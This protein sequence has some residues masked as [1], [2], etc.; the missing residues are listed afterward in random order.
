MP[1]HVIV[2][3]G[4]VGS[5]TA[6]RLAEAGHDIR[7]VTRSGHGPDHPGVERIAADA[8]DAARLTELAR[9]AHALYNCANPPYH[10]WATEWPPL[11][12]SFLAAAEATEARLITMSNLYGHARGTMPMRATDP[13]APPTRKGAIRTAMWHDALRA[14]GEGRIRATEARASDYV[15]PGL[16][17]TS[18][19][20]DRTIPR[21]LAG[22][23]VSLLGAADVIHSW[24]YIGDVCATLAT[25]GTDERSL[26]RAWHVPTL[27]PV[28]ARSMIDAIADA[29]AVPHVAVRRIPRPLLRAAG[30]FSPLVRE[31]WEM[32]Y[33]FDEPFVIDATDT[34]EVFGIQPTPLEHQVAEILH[35]YRSAVPSR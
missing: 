15:G 1:L 4:A 23:S 19:L 33:Q 26:G 18:H 27:P 24:S 6:L 29:A 16:G 5:G 20:G 32:R 30:M 25:L 17:D 13:L 11:A 31:L 9:G 3:A 7:L 28:T 8:S 2:G 22:K 21:V 10:R 34:T 35:S 12:S 14:H